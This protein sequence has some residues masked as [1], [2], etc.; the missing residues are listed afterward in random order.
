MKKATT[1]A[2][3]AGALTVGALGVWLGPSLM[4][5]DSD[6]AAPAAA[7]VSPSVETATPRR[8]PA[9]RAVASKEMGRTTIAPDVVP[10]L[11]ATQ[12]EL[13]ER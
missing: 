11:P 5:R 12:P 6:V 7:V 3:I 1:T 4:D 10:A 2:L 9:P 8:A 13:H